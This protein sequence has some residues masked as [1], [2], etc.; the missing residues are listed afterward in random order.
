LGREE[1]EMRREGEEEKGRS[2]KGRS[3]M[4]F[5]RGGGFHMRIHTFSIHIRA[6]YT[7]TPPPPP[8]SSRKVIHKESTRKSL[9]IV[10]IYFASA[11]PLAL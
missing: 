7:L 8:Q 4:G 1:G 2:E 5:K 10:S 9:R 11:A 6:H 3:E